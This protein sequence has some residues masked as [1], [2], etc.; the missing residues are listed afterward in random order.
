MEIHEWR[1]KTNSL[2]ALVHCERWSIKGSAERG[3]IAA[4]LNL[5]FPRPVSP[6]AA[7]VGD[8]PLGQ[9]L[10]PVGPGRS[11]T[12]SNQSNRSSL[13][14]KVFTHRTVSTVYLINN[15][16]QTHLVEKC[17]LTLRPVSGPVPR[18]GDVAE[19]GGEAHQRNIT[20]TANPARLKGHMCEEPRGQLLG[21]RCSLFH[22]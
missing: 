9:T 14:R 17:G 13:I 1:T 16:P 3:W 6:E 20:W 7:E 18:A 15:A 21:C 5:E 22:T 8:I 2:T 19:V 4:E 12:A 10:C 11:F